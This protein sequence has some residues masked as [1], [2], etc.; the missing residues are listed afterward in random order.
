[1]KGVSTTTGARKA[2]MLL[3]TGIGT[4]R[5]LHRGR[6]VSLVGEVLPRRDR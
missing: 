5:D 2:R 3:G 4:E 6:G 1:M